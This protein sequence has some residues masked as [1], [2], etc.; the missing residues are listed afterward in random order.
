VKR[1]ALVSLVVLAAAAV[2]GVGLPERAAA[3]DP[4]PGTLTV[5][6]TGAV[7]STPDRAE[8]SF[9]VESQAATAKAALAA[10]AT[11][12]RRLIDAL[13]AAGA[14]DVATQTV[15]VAPRYREGAALEIAGYSASNTVTVTIAVGRAGA[16]IDAGAAA[17]ANQIYG[18]TL[19]STDAA[20][21]YRGALKAAFEDA[22]AH[23][24]ALAAA[25]GASVGRVVSMV[26]GGGAPS[27]VYEAKIAADAA[28]TPVEPGPQQ[29]TA[30]VT[31]T[32]A[33]A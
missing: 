15:S 24:A 13:S 4:A 2:A 20:Q 17:G 21:L 29:T 7:T 11:E 14:K 33:L 19:S 22:R 10:N 23:A 18:P 25:A 6:G 31:V 28:S 32:F 27:P 8:L 5:T 3:V 12:M 9:G 26:E 1:I 16:L 30:A